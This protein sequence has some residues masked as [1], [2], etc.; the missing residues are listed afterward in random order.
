M[1]RAG[2]ATEVFLA[3]LRLGVTSFGGPVA[4]LGYFRDDLVVRRRWMDD[5]AYADLV[6][7]CQ[8]LPGPAS[9]QVGFAMGLQRAGVRGALAAFVAFTLPSAV[10]LVAFAVGASAIGGPVGEGVLSGLKIV[11]VAIVA[12]AVWGMART[13]TPDARRAGIAV[14]ALALALLLPA[15]PGQLGALAVGI[16]AGV[17]LLR[18]V[19]EPAAVDLPP[20][21]VRRA[22]AVMC[23]V[24]FG[25]ALV[26][27]PLLA[28]GTGS[29]VVSLV[30]TFFRSGALVFGGGHVVLPLLQAGV[31]QTGW[32]SPESFL[33]GYGAAQAVPGPL[34]TFA[35]YLGAVSDLGPG[36]VAGA[37]IALAAIFLPGFLV[38][39]GV[40]PFWDAVRRRPWVRA[41]MRGASAAVVGIL[42]AA[43]YAPVFTT[44]ITGPGSLVLAVLGFVLLT[45][46]KI[47]AWAV[48]LV[49]AAGG[50][51]LLSLS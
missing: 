37:A 51:V 17:L 11:A 29:G 19:E 18:G 8:F 5:R 9:S 34:F 49:G 20:F 36:G 41:A 3:F 42:G 26:I 30:D 4:H 2:T 40:L 38:L 32:V 45:A 25:A 21:G 43:L 1:Q 31:V 22:A 46:F 35:A 15:A 33:A 44:A 16:I 6:A 7:L 28:A 47:P 14:V 50:I 39:V 27:L 10:L 48:V 24:L 13:L 12:H 23:L